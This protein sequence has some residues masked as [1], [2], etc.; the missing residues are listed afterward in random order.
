MFKKSTFQS[1]VATCSDFRN[2]CNR[3]KNYNRALQLVLHGAIFFATCLAMLE[4]S[5]LQVGRDMLHISFLLC[6][7]QCLKKAHSSQELQLAVIS[8]ISVIVAR[9]TIELYSWCYTVQF[10]LQLVWQRWKKVDC[11]LEETCY[12][13][14]SYSATCNVKKMFQSGV[15]TCSDFKNLCN[16]CKN[17]NRALQLV[18]H[19]AIFFATCLATLEK[20]VHCKLQET[21]YMQKS[22][23]SLQE[24]QS[25]STAGVTW[26]NFLCNLCCNGVAR[27]VAL[28]NTPS[29]QFVSQL[30]WACN[31]CTK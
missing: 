4:K 11:K 31:N 25:S 20:K 18:L 28:C 17:Y 3:C 21:C 27:K 8:E 29:L 5:R 10:S 13:F 19:G 2:L 7:L 23:E 12:T 30:F 24:L 16:R 22:L 15:A 26:C 6:N 9:T 14:H 1:G